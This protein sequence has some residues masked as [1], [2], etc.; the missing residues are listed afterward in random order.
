M[1]GKSIKNIE[2]A[3]TVTT[4][5]RGFCKPTWFDLTVLWSWTFNCPSVMLVFTDRSV[6][7]LEF[8]ARSARSFL[9]LTLIFHF[10]CFNA[11]IPLNQDDSTG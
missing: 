5:L 8:Q 7:L 3:F 9:A 4:L 10:F 2:E 11:V 1:E 6:Y